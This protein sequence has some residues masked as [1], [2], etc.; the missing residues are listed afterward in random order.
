MGFQTIASGGAS[1]AMGSETTASNIRAVAMGFRTQASGTASTAMGSE[2][3]ASGDRSVAMGQFVEASGVNSAAMGVNSEAQAFASLGLGRFNVIAGNATT[4]VATDP[5]LVVGN[6][7]S[8]GFR[9]NALTLLKN[10]NLTIA[11]T[12]TENSDR[13]L[14]HNITPLTDALGTLARLQ[15]VRYRFR[16]G[17]NRPDGQHL[18]LIAQEVEAVYPELVQEGADGY[19]SVSYG[20]L[21]AV[22]VQALNEQQAEI[23]ALQDRLA[24]LE[25]ALFEGENT[26]TEAR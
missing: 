24:R 22:L 10:G 25:A 19:L 26:S 23:E 16:E 12:L 5:V 1:T 17:T 20:K 21:T 18:G 8:D 9:S 3:T 13:R 14:K 4:W 11:G 2:T 6:G 7:T 15:P